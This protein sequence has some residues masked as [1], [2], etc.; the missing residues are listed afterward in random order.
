[1][2]AV[3]NQIGQRFHSHCRHYFYWDQKLNFLRYLINRDRQTGTHTRARVHT[4][5]EMHTV[6]DMYTLDKQYLAAGLKIMLDNLETGF[7]VITLALHN[8]F[9]SLDILKHNRLIQQ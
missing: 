2:Y 4:H 3:M 9:I 7:L 6:R 8:A 5:T 1:M